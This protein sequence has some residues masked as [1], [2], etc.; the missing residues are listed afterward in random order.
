MKRKLKAKAWT[1]YGWVITEL[2]PVAV[3]VVLLSINID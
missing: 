1:L 3:V 2:M